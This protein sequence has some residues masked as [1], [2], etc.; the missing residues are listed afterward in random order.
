MYIGIYEIN[1]SRKQ[2]R[3]FSNWYQ[4]AIGENRNQQQDYIQ[5]GWKVLYVKLGAVRFGKEQKY[6]TVKK[7]LKKQ[8]G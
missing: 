2:H 5:A 3:P 1:V 4:L 6:V 8:G 7:N